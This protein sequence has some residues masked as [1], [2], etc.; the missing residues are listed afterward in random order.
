MSL[1]LH[2]AA[3]DA[4]GGIKCAV[5]AR[6]HRRDNRVIGSFAGLE[7][8]GV[9]RVEAEVVAAVLQG[10]TK[11]FRHD[12]RT[13]APVIAVDK[14]TGIAP[15]IHDG[16]IDRIGCIDW[17]AV[18]RVDRGT[19]SINELTPLGRVLF[20]KQFQDRHIRERWVGDVP[21]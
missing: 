11:A 6:H 2:E 17:R 4:V 14:R 16:E 13:E 12:T 15:L 5:F 9:L 18:F 21:A 3:H 7:T 20:R 19:M 1:R 8:V 10:E